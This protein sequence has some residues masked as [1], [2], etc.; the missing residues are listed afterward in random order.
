MK[1]RILAL[2]LTLCLCLGLV[3]AVS[4]ATGASAAGTV[5]EKDYEVLP[6]YSQMDPEVAIT[7]FFRREMKLNPAAICGNLRNYSDKG[8]HFYAGASI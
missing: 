5:H 6:D 1:Q 3:P 8:G 2:L 7:T 4:A